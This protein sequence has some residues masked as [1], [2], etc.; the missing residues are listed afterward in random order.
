ML[1]HSIF[2]TEVQFNAPIKSGHASGM[3]GN[4]S[5]HPQGN[6]ALADTYIIQNPPA[7]MGD[8]GPNSANPL[9]YAGKASLTDCPNCN[10]PIPDWGLHASQ[11]SNFS[12][13]EEAKEFV[14]DK[15]KYWIDRISAKTTTTS[16]RSSGSKKSKSKKR[17]KKKRSWR[18]HLKTLRRRFK[19]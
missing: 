2:Q 8:R 11:R 15:N 17:S 3:A 18:S 6:P 7:F 13:L 4:Q 14:E 10:P 19:W 16:G 9:V 1:E 12:T 5:N